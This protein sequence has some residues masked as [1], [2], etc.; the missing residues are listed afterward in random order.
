MP[1][2]KYEVMVDEADYTT[3]KTGRD[4]IAMRLVVT[5]PST[6][7]GEKFWYR[8]WS[9]VDPF[10][11]EANGFMGRKI[12]MFAKTLEISQSEAADWHTFAAKTLYKCFTVVTGH[13]EGNDGRTYVEVKA[14]APPAPDT[15][16]P[17]PPT[18]G[19]PLAPGGAVPPP[20]PALA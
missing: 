2:G 4:G 13:R 3:A 1:P 10:T 7:T 18:D 14:V 17:A 6:H 5:A 12:A 9:P 8:L 11:G 16:P 20:P 15:A 19:R